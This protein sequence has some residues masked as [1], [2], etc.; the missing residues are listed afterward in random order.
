[1]LSTPNVEDSLREIA[2]ITARMLPDRP[3]VAVTLRRNGDTVTVASTG[4]HA[5]LIDEL[6]RDHGL[7]P[8]LEALHTAAPVAIPDMTDE[9][10]WG[11]YPARM[12]AR[13]IRSAHSQPLLIDG[14]AVGTLNVYSPHPNMFGA[15]ALPAIALTSAHTAVLLAA[16]I[17]SARQAALTAQLQSALASRSLIDQALGITMAQRRCD[18]DAAFEVLRVASQHEN[19][20]IVAVA[21]GIIRAITGNDPTP[22]H[23]NVPTRPTPIRRNS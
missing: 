11:A 12:L 19:I 14:V 5:S 2:D 13:G 22:P 6:A 20:K 4:P 23:F 3:M 18:R 7:G 17:Q 10:R 15:A 1:M 21:A 16:A 8:C 9:R